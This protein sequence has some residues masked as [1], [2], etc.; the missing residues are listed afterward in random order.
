[1]AA[2]MRRLDTTLEGC[3]AVQRP[4]GHLFDGVHFVSST[5]G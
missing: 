2:A 3:A 1:L 5:G 4:H